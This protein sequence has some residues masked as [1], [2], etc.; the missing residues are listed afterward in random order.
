M[1]FLSCISS[2]CLPVMGCSDLSLQNA[3]DCGGIYSS[4][5]PSIAESSANDLLMFASGWIW[6]IINKGMCCSSQV[7]DLQFSFDSHL[8]R[9]PGPMC[10]V[11]RLKGVFV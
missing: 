7:Y 6:R 5:C 8:P 9:L 10:P 11:V 3:A 4:L 1:D 2:A